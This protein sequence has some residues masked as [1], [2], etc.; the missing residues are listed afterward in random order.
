MSL[1]P[2]LLIQN[3]RQGPLVD[4]VTWLPV[5][6][7]RDCLTY[8]SFCSMK[9]GPILTKMCTLR[10]ILEKERGTSQAEKHH[11]CI[12]QLGRLFVLP[13]ISTVF[14]SYMMTKLRNR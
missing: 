10:H 1:Y 8:F 6:K 14:F 5:V 2:Y 11:R 9:K 12:V 4:R 7:R 13:E 3:L